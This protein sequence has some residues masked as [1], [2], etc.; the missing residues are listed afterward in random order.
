MADGREFDLFLICMYG[1]MLT[2]GIV[3][4]ARAM[5]IAEVME[6]FRV[7][8]LQIAACQANPPPSQAQ[9]RG[10]Q[11]LRQCHTEAQLLLALPFNAAPASA[12]NSPGENTKRQLQKYAT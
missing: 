10:Y 2:K 4:D 6:H 8:Q 9:A 3:N 11:V 12:P 1:K 7:I 5:R